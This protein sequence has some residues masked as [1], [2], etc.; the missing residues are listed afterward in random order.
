VSEKHCG[1]QEQSSAGAFLPKQHAVFFS[2]SNFLQSTPPW[3]LDFIN[4]LLGSMDLGDD[5]SVF[6][7]SD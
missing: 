3:I 1:R 4:F 6:V 2:S 5:A 7:E